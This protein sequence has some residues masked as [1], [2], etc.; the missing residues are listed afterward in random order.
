[1][2]TAIAILSVSVLTLLSANSRV[3]A[4]CATGL[5]DFKHSPCFEVHIDGNVQASGVLE[6]HDE[7]M[8]DPAREAPEQRFKTPS[9]SANGRAFL[10]STGTFSGNIERFRQLPGVQ[11]RATGERPIVRDLFLRS[12]EHWKQYPVERLK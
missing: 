11:Q 3:G 6:S 10:D 2:R 8:S 12:S 5:P 1:M 7:L 4:Q 9:L